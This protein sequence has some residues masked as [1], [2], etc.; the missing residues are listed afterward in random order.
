[1]SKK[2]NQK[3]EKTSAK[4]EEK[5]VEEKPQKVEPPRENNVIMATKQFVKILK[6]ELKK[7]TISKSIYVAFMSSAPKV[8]TEEN[9]R[10]IWKNTFRRQ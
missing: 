1:M 5:S 9:Y 4:V 8:D 3:D 2:D 10:K 7:E 6:D